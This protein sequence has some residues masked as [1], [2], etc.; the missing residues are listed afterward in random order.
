M[1]RCPVCGAEVI[2]PNA[3]HCTHCGAVLNVVTVNHCTNPACPLHAS[4]KNFG[5]DV[6]YCPECGSLTT[7]GKQIEDLI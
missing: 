4:G 2:F 3:K 7:I 5:P 1:A 6:S